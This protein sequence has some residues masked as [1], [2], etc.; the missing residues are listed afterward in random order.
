M[1]TALK[2]SGTGEIRSVKVGWSWV[3]FLFSWFLGLPLFLRGLPILGA[4]FL[5]LFAIKLV[6]P[7]VSVNYAQTRDIISLINLLLFGLSIWLGIKGNEYTG[8][9][10]LENGWTFYDP[11]SESAKYAQQ[12]WRIANIAREE[13]TAK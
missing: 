5:S 12:K 13:A 8:K 7:A 6:L 9:R 3:L 4:I 10:L 2:H 1:K 11:T